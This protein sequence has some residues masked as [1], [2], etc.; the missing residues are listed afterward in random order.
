MK[1]QKTNHKYYIILVVVVGAGKLL[2]S[3]SGFLNKPFSGGK[4]LCGKG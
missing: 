4:N 2:K 1:K 3:P